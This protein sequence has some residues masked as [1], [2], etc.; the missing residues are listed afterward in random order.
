MSEHVELVRQLAERWNAG[1]VEGALALY[2]DD[3]V[4][5]SG[6]A[7]PEQAVHRGQDELR[8]NM[9]DWLAVW[10]TSQI[11]I[12]SIE[13]YGEKVVATGSWLTRGRTSGVSGRMPIVILLTLRHGKIAVLEWFDDH[14]DAVTAARGA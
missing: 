11:D 4:A 1:D 10:E 3:A 9:R 12:G 5:I 8:S 13:S 7:W 14:D 2:T 6:P